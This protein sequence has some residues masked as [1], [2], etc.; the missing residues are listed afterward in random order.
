[1]FIQLINIVWGLLVD[2]YCCEVGDIVG[3][4][5][6][7]IDIVGNFNI[8]NFSVVIM[9]NI[10]LICLV[11]VFVMI[12]CVDLFIG[13]DLEDEEVLQGLFGMVQGIDVCNIILIDELDL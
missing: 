12:S 4:E 6:L 9:D 1:M 3:V 10:V 2:F 5:L 11:L 13:E 8:C 7:V